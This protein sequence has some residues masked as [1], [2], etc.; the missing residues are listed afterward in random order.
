MS[1]SLQ[2]ALTV[3]PLGFYL[4]IIA[5]W[6]SGQR[7]RVVNGLPDFVLL[8]LG[9]GGVLAFGPFGQLLAHRLFKHPDA[10]DWLTI[11]SS[12]GLVA[13]ILARRSI[14]RV[15][16][17]HI[18]ESDVAPVLE[19]VLRG[20][21]VPF[22]RTMHG[23]EDAT[24]RRGLRVEVTRSLRCVFIEALGPDPDR[25]IQVV[26]KGLRERLRSVNSPPNRT[27]F[28]FYAASLA[29]MFAPLISDFL[30]QPIA[31]EVLRVFLERIRGG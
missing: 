16:V 10:F 24:G 5:F 2:Y 8:T 18:R 6:H 25:L 14:H 23:Y 29:V 13:T 3:G 7:P 21:P 19:D 31:R 27:A 1:P 17:Y 30:A 9:V 4:W 26:R 15:V 20:E 12:L 11:V 22:L 28:G